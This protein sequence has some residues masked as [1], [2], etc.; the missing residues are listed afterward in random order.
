MLCF[1]FIQF[2]ADKTDVKN[3]INFKYTLY[4]TVIVN[5]DV[6]FL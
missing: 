2:N 6:K 5:I 3:K 1:V 4:N